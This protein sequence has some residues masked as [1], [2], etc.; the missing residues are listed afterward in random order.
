M[1]VG[2][3]LREIIERSRTRRMLTSMS[4]A[5]AEDFGI[6]WVASRIEAARPWWQPVDWPALAGHGRLQ[7]GGAPSFRPSFDLLLRRMGSR[8]YAA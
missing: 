7:P 5:V 4:P 6:D 1:E 2:A 3:A 8:G